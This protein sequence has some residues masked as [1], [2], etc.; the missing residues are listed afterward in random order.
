MHS[1]ETIAD[2]AA[3]ALLLELDATPK[4]GLVDRRN[5]GAH[6]DMDYAMFRA[7]IEAVRPC[8]AAFFQLAWNFAGPPEALLEAARPIGIEAERDMLRATGG[9]NTHK[10]AIFSLGILCLGIARGAPDAEALLSR[11]AKIAAPALADFALVT[12]QTARSHG[13]RQY[14]RYRAAG[15]RGEA[16]AG[17]PS[18]RKFGLPALRGYLRGGAS[19]NDAG[20]AALLH[21]MAGV[22]DT[23]ILKRGGL[24]ALQRTQADLSTFLRQEP[25]LE[26][27]L[28][29]A[30]AL[31]EAFIA[32]HIS[33]GGCADLLSAAW[34]LYLVYGDG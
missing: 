9:V 1:A 31:D 22:E 26:A 29:R 17:F 32:A 27:I 14:L 4:P 11:C 19:R 15:A 12:D 13:E 33:P 8:F 7:S 21:L 10:G 20:V 6:R 5:S 2:Y 25:T 28:E 23:N 30:A 16:A 24:D 3:Q 34:F 18:V